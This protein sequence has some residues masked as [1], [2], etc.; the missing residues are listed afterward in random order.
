MKLFKNQLLV[1]I[2][3]LIALVTSC[4]PKTPD[5]TEVELL[6]KTWRVSRATINGQAD[7]NTNY[8]AFRITFQRSDQTPTN[9]TVVPGNAPRPNLSP[10]NTGT[11]VL[12]ADKKQITLDR[13]NATAEITLTIVGTILADAVTISW[14]VPRTVDKT[15]RPP[16]QPSWVFCFPAYHLAHWVN[17]MQSP[18]KGPGKK[19]V[20]I[21]CQILPTL[22]NPNLEEQYADE[23]A[24]IF[25]LGSHIPRPGPH[26]HGPRTCQVQSPI[27]G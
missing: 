3:A 15:E 18:K 9:Y 10:T 14:K 8:S 23:N 19:R 26:D 4:G 25:C 17:L 11:W 6:A 12:S 7:N 27:D 5:P 1:V 22:S 16:A 13:G 20:R 21:L 2:L 24:P